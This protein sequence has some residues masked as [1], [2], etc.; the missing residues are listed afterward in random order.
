M[1][2][3]HHNFGYNSGLPLYVGDRYFGQDRARDFWSVL[4]HI[5]VT[6]EGFLG[7]KS[8]LFKGEVIQ[9]S[10][11]NLIN[12]SE[13]F[14]IVNTQVDIVD[15][16]TAIPFPTT[17]E[18]LSLPV[19]SAAQADVSLSGATLD[20]TSTNYVKVSY[21]ETT[22]NSRAR[23]KA[24]GS[25]DS[26]AQPTLTVTVNTTAPTTYELQIA[27]LVGD[28]STF[29]NIT[30]I[31]I[32]YTLPRI[33]SD[34][35]SISGN[36]EIGGSL[37]VT[38]NIESD[39]A[40]HATAFNTKRP[41]SITLVG[42]GLDISGFEGSVAALGP[43]RIAVFSD[44]ND[45]LFTLDFNGTDWVS[46]GNT[47]N[48]SGVFVWSM[49]AL[50]PSRVVLASAPTGTNELRAYDFNGTDWS[51]AGSSFTVSGA[52]RQSVDALSPS[53]ICFVDDGNDQLRTYDFNGSAF[54]LVGSGLAL[55]GLDFVSIASLETDL[56]ALLHG[57]SPST[58]RS[59]RFD[60]S[61]WSEYGASLSGLILGVPHYMRA[62]STRRVLVAQDTSSTMDAFELSHNT[63]GDFGWRELNPSITLASAFDPSMTMLSPSS[64]A[65]ASDSNTNS[66]RK[67]N[68][69]FGGFPPSLA[70]NNLS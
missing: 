65:L 69:N 50:S 12:I 49:C 66:I 32:E 33:L 17:T 56:V 38:K 54:S 30:D 68:I 15:S 2:I 36:V 3:K 5:G 35:I 9:G 44:D 21:S 16:F 31:N 20:G 59:Y 8:F 63:S 62:F 70:F 39:S 1:I 11:V 43:N 14:G 7:N 52:G 28:G 55:P 29:L 48:L 51:Q 46:V 41:E 58:L 10:S 27:T 42:N 18:D 40:V 26:E 37:E 6:W 47:L 19:F 25:Y 61:V 53:R 34:F 4:S 67:F 24:A 45:T 60:G 13:L 22:L 57:P 23:A 64:F